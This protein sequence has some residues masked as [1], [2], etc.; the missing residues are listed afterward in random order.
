MPT[1]LPTVMP[2]DP[3]S[4]GGRSLGG[5][6]ESTAMTAREMA[7]LKWASSSTNSLPGYSQIKIPKIDN[8]DKPR[9][10]IQKDNLNGLSQTLS[11]NINSTS[12]SSDVQK[13]K[14][15][16]CSKLIEATK[17]NEHLDICLTSPA[18]SV[19]EDTS[20][21][22]KSIELDDSDMFNDSDDEMLSQA[23]DDAETSMNSSGEAAHSGTKGRINYRE[24]NVIK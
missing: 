20:A 8:G 21:P 7:R 18:T 17:I 24:K 10:N 11:N 16:V 13:S 2:S 22:V 14:C 23:L 15:P 12:S 3:S 1:I 6:V 19:S 5:S 9:F 4:F